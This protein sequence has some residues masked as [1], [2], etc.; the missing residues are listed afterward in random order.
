MK[1]KIHPDPHKCSSCGG[2]FHEKTCTATVL[3]GPPPEGGYKDSA[4][5]F[6][7]LSAGPANRAVADLFSRMAVGEKFD[8]DSLR[9]FASVQIID[10]G[11]SIIS[12]PLGGR[13]DS[14]VSLSE[15]LLFWRQDMD[16]ASSPDAIYNILGA[17]LRHSYACLAD[18]Q[19][20]SGDSPIEEMLAVLARPLRGHILLRFRH[21]FGG[22]GDVSR[23]DI[24]TANRFFDNFE[25]A[26]EVVLL[27][28]EGTPRDIPAA[29]YEWTDQVHAGCPIV[30]N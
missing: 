19:C 22:L 27:P 30:H 26:G 16:S 12:R 4:P 1:K 21:V 10:A 11:T 25:A 13:N 6:N 2:R 28:I 17:V 24:T 14:P 5:T 23:H 20:I 18:L 15:L 7:A 29:V 8:R 3:Q 9:S